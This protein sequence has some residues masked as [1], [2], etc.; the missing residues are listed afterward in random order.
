M[1]PVRSLAT[2]GTGR[3]AS[4]STSKSQPSSV[5]GRGRTVRRTSPVSF[6]R[7]GL[8]FGCLKEVDGVYYCSRFRQF[9]VSPEGR[10][11]R[12][13]VSAAIVLLMSSLS[14]AEPLRAQERG[15]VL[16]FSPA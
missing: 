7:V 16:K 11:V 13:L 1:T 9:M 12:F 15:G 4:T 5:A 14:R 8:W 6:H 10:V 3:S 2:G